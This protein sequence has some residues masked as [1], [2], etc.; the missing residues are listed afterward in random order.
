KPLSFHS[1]AIELAERFGWSTNPI[2]GKKAVGRWK[3]FQCRRP[4]GDTLRRLFSRDGITGLAVITGAVSGGLAIRD[5]DDNEA[6]IT[7]TAA[8]QTGAKRLPTVK[9]ARGYHVYGWMDREAYADFGNGELRGDSKHYC[10]I[11]PS[12]HPGGAVYRWVNPLPKN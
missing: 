4:D 3:E 9:T 11:P 6:Y 10:V 8:N 1:R 12:L 7:W 2:V 5:F